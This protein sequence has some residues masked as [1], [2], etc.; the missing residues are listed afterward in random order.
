MQEAQQTTAQWVLQKIRNAHQE[1]AEV[2]KTRSALEKIEADTKSVDRL[3]K[4]AVRRITFYEKIKAA[5]E[6]GY[7]IIPP[8]AVQ[9]FAIRVP[10]NS[11]PK[12]DRSRASWNADEST[13]RLPAGEG[14]WV[15]PRAKREHVETVTEQVPSDTSKTREIAIYEN[16]SDWLKVDIPIMAQKPE[17]IDAVR[18]AMEARIF[19]ALGIAPAY[20]DADPIIVGQIKHWRDRANP[21][22]FFVAWWMNEADL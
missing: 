4:L 12:I 8:F 5:L 3:A 10:E 11:S 7:V 18:G 20:R 16:D 13:R 9:A 21:L 15:H 22:T 14:R 2:A 17:I 6:R 1:L 19:D